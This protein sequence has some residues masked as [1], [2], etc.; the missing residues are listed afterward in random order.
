[1]FQLDLMERWR[2]CEDEA[3]AGLVA[4]L[5]SLYVEEQR[6]SKRKPRRGSDS[7]AT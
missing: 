5:A 4:D 2:K 7:T 3:L 1:M 6:A